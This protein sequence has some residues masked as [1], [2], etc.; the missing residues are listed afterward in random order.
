MGFFG[1][2]ELPGMKHKIIPSYNSLYKDVHERELPDN[3]LPDGDNIIFEDGKVKTRWGYDSLGSNLPLTG[4]VMSFLEFNKLRSTDEKLLALTSS[5]GY[6]YTAGVW[7][8]ITA[9]YNTGTVSNKWGAVSEFSVAD[10]SHLSVCGIDSTHIAVAYNR[11]SNGYVR[12]ATISDDAISSWGA[13]SNFNTGSTFN[14]SIILIDS[15]HLGVAF[16]D[17]TSGD[18][19]FRICE[20]SGETVSSWGTASVFHTGDTSCDYIT[21]VLVDSTHAAV[22]FQDYSESSGKLVICEFSGTTISSWGSEGTFSSEAYYFSLCKIDGTH[23]AVAYATGTV[24]ESRICTISG[25][26]ISSWGTASQFLGTLPFDI[27]IA[28]L[29]STHIAVAYMNLIYDGGEFQIATISGESISS[30]DKIGKFNNDSSGT[31][32]DKSLAVMGDDLIVGYETVS[33]DQGIIRLLATQGTTVD[34]WGT[35]S[36]FG[37]H[38]SYYMS[39]VLIDSTRIAV[40]YF[41]PAAN[42]A[43]IKIGT[44]AGDTITS[45]GAESIFNT[46]ATMSIS[47]VLIDSTH[48]AVAHQSSGGVGNLRICEFSGETVSS[49]GDVSQFA[50]SASQISLTLIDSTHMGVA[51]SWTGNGSVRICEFSGTTVSSWGTVS[52]FNAAVSEYNSLVLIDS[53]HLGV[54]Y[55]DTGNSNYGT[56]RVCTFSGTTVSSWG[57]ESVFNSADTTYIK[58]AKTDTNYLAIAYRN[59]TDGCCTVSVAE[60]SGETATCSSPLIFGSIGTIDHINLATIDKNH[61]AVVYRSTSQLDLRIAT[62]SSMEVLLCEE[63]S[64]AASATSYY[65]CV[66]LL[67]STHLAV[68]YQDADDSHYGKAKICNLTRETNNYAFSEAVFAADSFYV[69]LA[70]IDSDRVVVIFREGVGNTGQAR[71]RNL[72]IIE[73]SGTTWNSNWI[74]DLYYMKFNTDE[75]DGDATPMEWFLIHDITSNT[76][77][78]L[79]NNATIIDGSDYIIDLSFNSTETNYFDSTS[80]IEGL[81]G[82]DDNWAII[83]NGI[84]P[85]LKYTGT[86]RFDIIEGEPPLARYCISYHGF[87]M[88]GWCIVSGNN[89]PQSVYW[90]NRGEPE[91]WSTGSASYIDLLEGDDWIT[92]MEMLK[93]RMFVFK[94]NSIVECQYTGLVAPAFS[95]IEDRIKGIGAISGLSIK[96][97]GES[98]FFL[99][100]DNIYEFN[101]FQVNPIGKPII[102][103]LL[104]NLNTDYLHKAF[105]KVIPYK[106]LYCLSIVSK[107]ATNPDMTYV[108]NYINK[109]WSLWSYA[110]FITAAGQYGNNIVLGDNSGYVYQ[111]DYT[112]D[113][114]NGSNISSFFETKDYTLNDNVFRLLQNLITAE[115]STGIL[116]ISCSTDF[117][118]TWSNPI[119]VDMNSPLSIYKHKLNWNKRC[120]RIRFK[121][122][123]VSGSRFFV[124]E[125]KIGFQDA[126]INY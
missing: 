66:I 29:D 104:S 92:G 65:N 82:S 20:F 114:D 15:T 5:N 110:D 86:G 77:L 21:C 44:Y 18:G 70:K 33:D 93:Q 123:N 6:V 34:S 62:I 91:Q 75:L 39:S 106:N 101:G 117:G 81:G 121:I 55:R 1:R 79:S 10:P 113:D 83:T 96:N 9:L 31:Y 94:E 28:L 76:I 63:I 12:I 13:E 99:G 35:E 74:N 60:I 109:S 14:N 72:K 25:T 22:A 59:V 50:A 24:G 26:T 103:D 90:C 64:I 32:M 54:T 125:F 102:K 40:A 36:E 17:F 98:I 88:L 57:A 84:D 124:E 2:G 105:A 78:E 53:T 3:L 107:S 11:S 118:D 68:I 27:N 119:L 48:L 42:E 126:G 4:T 43:K 49:W 19:M 41:Y 37:S 23:L 45:W 122:E 89:L 8:D 52:Q 116:S 71:I 87:L 115:Q 51:Y 67:D 80:T 46:V 58:S 69:N 7:D 120:E 47:L 97:L 56:I 38:A 111:M 100:E 112:D 85:V 30:W 61:I 108:Y 73:G 95:F 16:E